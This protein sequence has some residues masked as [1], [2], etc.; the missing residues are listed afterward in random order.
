MK[1][2]TFIKFRLSEEQKEA[3]KNLCKSKGVGLSSLIIH[4]VENKI[5]HNE[6]REILSFIEKQENI[7]AKIE[8]NINQFAKIAN[9][10]KYVNEKELEAFNEHLE[11]LKRLRK[12][13]IQIFKEIY[14]L[15]AK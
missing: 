10:Y 7:Y 9:L 8:N 13:Q 2:G 14:K 12:E 15:L 11:I 6:K 4:S 5:L 1:K 3:W